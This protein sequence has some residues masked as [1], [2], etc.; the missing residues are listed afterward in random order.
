MAC[1]WLPFNQSKLTVD[2][3]TQHIAIYAGKNTIDAGYLKAGLD[4]VAQFTLRKTII[5]VYNQT[6]AIAR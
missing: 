2:T 6:D 5:K 1:R 3:A 4:A